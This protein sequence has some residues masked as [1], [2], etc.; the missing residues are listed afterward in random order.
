MGSS[1][2]QMGIHW[3]AFEEFQSFLVHIRSIMGC[4]VSTLWYIGSTFCNVGNTLWYTLACIAF[5]STLDNVRST[6][7]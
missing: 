2:R 1:L 4:F 7:W 3:G 5:A 6:F